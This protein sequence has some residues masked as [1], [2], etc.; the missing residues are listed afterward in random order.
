MINR[1]KSFFSDRQARPGGDGGHHTVDEFHLAAAALL[2]HAA[3]ID[4]DFDDAERAKILELAENKLDLS[5]EEARSL[6]QAAEKAAD[7]SVQLLGFT[8]AVKDKF[9]YEERVEL[10]EMLWEVVYADGE[11][12]EFESQLMRRIG[13]LIY[14]TDRDRGIARKR[15]LERLD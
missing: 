3:S 10:L 1:I 9:S 6:L 13:G 4:T 15:V 14:V 8:R 2:V 5:A 7:E 11:V 12:D